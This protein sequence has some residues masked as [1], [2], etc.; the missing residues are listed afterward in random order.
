M[1][2]EMLQFVPF[3]KKVVI[4]LMDISKNVQITKPVWVLGGVIVNGALLVNNV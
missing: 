2:V 3:V 4:A 1:V